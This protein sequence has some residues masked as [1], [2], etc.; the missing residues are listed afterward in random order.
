MADAAKLLA[1]AL[2]LPADERAELA[3]RLLDSLE[4]PQGLSIDDHTELEVRAAEALR[5]APGIAWDDL[6]R[7]LSK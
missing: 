7:S 4:Q 1:Q 5:G 2:S 6:K 3:A